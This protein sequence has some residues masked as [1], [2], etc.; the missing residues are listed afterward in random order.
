MWNFKYNSDTYIQKLGPEEKVESEF[1][2]PLSSI[3]YYNLEMNGSWNIENDVNQQK[4]KKKK[5]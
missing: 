5:S 4:K 2:G 3:I 1:S